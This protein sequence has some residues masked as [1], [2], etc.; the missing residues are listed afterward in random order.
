MIFVRQ[1][2]KEI[3]SSLSI[4]GLNLLVLLI[5]QLFFHS[6][7]GQVN[8]ASKTR[9]NTFKNRSSVHLYVWFENSWFRIFNRTFEKHKPYLTNPIMAGEGALASSSL[10]ALPLSFSCY[11]LSPTLICCTRPVVTAVVRSDDTLWWLVSGPIS[12]YELDA[13]ITLQY[14]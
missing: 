7:D 11:S 3:N 14:Q 9:N 12:Q 4:T 5:S 10:P 2:Q 13:V 8:I 6:L 1:I